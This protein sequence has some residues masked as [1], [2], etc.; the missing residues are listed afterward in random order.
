MLD[1]NYYEH[2]KCDRCGKPVSTIFFVGR[3]VASSGVFSVCKEC[4][5]E[6]YKEYKF[7]ENNNHD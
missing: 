3:R 4:Y 6:L 2:H 1:I 7:N 5:D